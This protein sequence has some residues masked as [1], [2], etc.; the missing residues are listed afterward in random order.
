MVPA[1]PITT[2]G[3]VP[4]QAAVTPDSNSPNSLD[5]PIKSEFTAL[6]RPRISSG[7]ASWIKVIRTYT[8]TIAEA[9]SIVSATIDLVKSVESP[10][11]IVAT[12]KIISLGYRA[13]C[14]DVGCKNLGRLLF[15]YADA[16]GRPI[17]H[18]VLCHAHARMKLARN[19]G[20]RAQDLR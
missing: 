7:V 14:T 19:R 20:R 2:E 10:N 13:R 18:P 1:P 15:I 6:T 3:T 11:I 8:L 17:S 12:T 5:A 9:S 16:G 4:N